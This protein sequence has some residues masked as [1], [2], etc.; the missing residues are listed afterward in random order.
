M[1]YPSFIRHL[2]L[3]LN[4]NQVKMTWVSKLTS[5]PQD[6]FH[7]I[8]DLSWDDSREYFLVRYCSHLI[9]H[10]QPP[11]VCF[12]QYAKL[13]AISQRWNTWLLIALTLL[14]KTSEQYLPI[15]STWNKLL[16]HLYSK[17]TYSQCQVYNVV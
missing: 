11:A 6:I 4:S 2:P 14:L 17:T 3:Y 10:Y 12:L 15:M 5:S 7:N 13:A 9:L 16:C 8:C 1:N